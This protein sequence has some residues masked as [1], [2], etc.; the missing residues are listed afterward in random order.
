MAAPTRSARATASG[1]AWDKAQLAPVVL[2]HGAE[3]LLV[4]RAVERLTM[5]AREA[6]PETERTVVDASAY[7]SGM[8]SVLTSPSLFGEPRIVVLAGAQAA[9]D[10][11]LTD[12]I[13]YVEAPAP[14]VWLVVEHRGGV[15]G[16]KMLDAVRSSGAPVVACEPIKKDTDKV[17]FASAEFKRASRRASPGA[18]RALVEAVGSDLREL[19]S[20]CAQLVA[21]SERAIDEP[22]VEKYYG[23]RVEASGFRVADAAI[24]GDAGQAV[25][26]LRHALAT[27]ADPVPVV[28][29]LAMKLRT[30]AKVAG[31][32][33]HGRSAADLG[34]AP[35]QV[36]RARRDLAGWTPE[37]LAAA[38]SATAQADAEV[39]G[40]GRDPVFAVERA[41][42][43]VARSAG[44]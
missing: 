27:G 36:D 38:I 26:L 41:V 37:G 21:D 35:W 14:D 8:L 44:R 10:A 31:L 29:A 2:V 25:S 6:D 40:A 43:V 16:K 19:A 17:A 9:S 20:A 18:V 22:A 12:V 7:Q 32:R 24:A 3:G 33:G 4:D 34:L 1:T 23:G 15:R 28:A 42:L 11:L 13:S 39:K 30:L 5:L